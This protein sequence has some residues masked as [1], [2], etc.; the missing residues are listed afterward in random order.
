VTCDV[1]Q[2]YDV[3]KPL[4]KSSVDYSFPFS[5]V[6]NWYK[7]HNNRSRNTRVT[8]ENKVSRFY[9]SQCIG[10]QGEHK[11]VAP[12]FLREILHNC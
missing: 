11:I 10:L 1:T 2:S 9:S 7:K 8:V 12:R 4:T 5:L 6:Q 3:I